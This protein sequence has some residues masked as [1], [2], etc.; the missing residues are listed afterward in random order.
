MLHAATFSILIRVYKNT[1]IRIH[2]SGDLLLSRTAPTESRNVTTI[3]ARALLRSSKCNALLVVICNCNFFN[4]DPESD[5]YI[6]L[7]I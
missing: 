3:C 5:A 7:K 6:K 1:H 4:S 2:T